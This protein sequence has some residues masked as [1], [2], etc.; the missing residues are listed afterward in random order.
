MKQ[1]FLLPALVGVLLIGAG[2]F[3]AFS[4]KQ[5]MTIVPGQQVVSPERKTYTKNV[6]IPDAKDIAGLSPSPSVTPT[7]G[8]VSP[9]AALSIAPSGVLTAEVSPTLSQGKTTVAPTAVVV[10]KTEPPVTGATSLLVL[11]GGIFAIGLIAISF[12][13]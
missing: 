7:T 2:L 6:Y 5:E 12:V 11:I 1:S 10:K 4:K 13:L 9:T 8:I 3:F